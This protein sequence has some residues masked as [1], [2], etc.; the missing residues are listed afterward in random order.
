[1]VEEDDFH[2]GC[3]KEERGQLPSTCIIAIC[4][5]VFNIT[6]SLGLGF[7]AENSTEAA[8]GHTCNGG[9]VPV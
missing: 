1:M 4:K 5:D 3:G 7:Q 2:W 8:M 9:H 6:Y